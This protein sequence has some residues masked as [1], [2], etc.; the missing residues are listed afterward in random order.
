MS[1]EMYLGFSD[2]DYS[3][4]R[5]TRIKAI[6]KEKNGYWGL[7]DNFEDDLPPKGK[8]FAIAAALSW[9]K[10][11]QLVALKVQPN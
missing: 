10:R 2:F 4:G 9:I 5:G 1:D 8:A 6:A 11:G 3:S 7:A